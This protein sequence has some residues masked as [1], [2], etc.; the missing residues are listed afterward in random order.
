MNT[1]GNVGNRKSDQHS[2]E[3]ERIFKRTYFRSHVGVAL[4]ILN[5]YPPGAFATTPIADCRSRDM[6]AAAVI[7]VAI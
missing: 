3:T 6:T 7:R 5:L 1:Q 2:E 4:F